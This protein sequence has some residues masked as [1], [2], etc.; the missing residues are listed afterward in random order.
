MVTFI[1]QV[2]SEYIVNDSSGR[3]I[4]EV[5][6]PMEFENHY[7]THKILPSDL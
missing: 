2:K 3:V 4:Q 5:P 1:G 6:F 7:L